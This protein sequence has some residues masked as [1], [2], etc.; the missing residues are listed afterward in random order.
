MVT[1]AFGADSLGQKP[2]TYLGTPG[3]KAVAGPHLFG[4]VY[5][6]EEHPEVLL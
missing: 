2:T 6:E 1:Y 5:D 3:K 4:L